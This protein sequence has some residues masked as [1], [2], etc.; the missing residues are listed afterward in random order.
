[1]AEIESPRVGKDYDTKSVGFL[2]LS[3]HLIIIITCNMNIYLH[4][5]IFTKEKAIFWR[6]SSRRFALQLAGFCTTFTGCQHLNIFIIHQEGKGTKG[7]WGED[8][9]L[10]H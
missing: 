5:V 8:V 2:L 7:R 9:S 1:M 3:T 6:M 10:K 4:R